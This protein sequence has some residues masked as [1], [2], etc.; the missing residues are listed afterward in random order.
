MTCASAAIAAPLHSS[1]V[2]LRPSL[3]SGWV[4]VTYKDAQVAVPSSFSVVYPNEQYCGVFASTGTIF[5]GA[6]AVSQTCLENQSPGAQVTLV[7]MR[8]QYFSPESLQG[9]KSIRQDGLRL[10]LVTVNGAP[11]YYSPALGMEVAANGPDSLGV[12]STFAPSPRRVVLAAGPAPQVPSSW[13]TISF[14]GLSFPVPFDWTVK[15]TNYAMGIGQICSVPGVAL[16]LA[17]SVVLSTDQKF[18]AVFC[19]LIGQRPQL[20]VDGVQIDSGPYAPTV[21]ASSHCLDLKAL[22]ACLAAGTSY[23][24][25][26]LVLRVTVP[27]R[28]KPV[29]VSIG[30]AGSGMVAR[31]ILYSLRASLAGGHPLQVAGTVAGTLVRLGS[32]AP[33]APVALPGL[34]TARSSAARNSTAT[35]GKRGRFVLSVSPGEYKLTGHSPLVSQE[36]CTAAQLVRVKAGQEIS[37]VE[38]VCST[39]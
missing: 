34:V 21:T 3:A 12:L 5:L 6:V 20:P 15:R 1:S 30:L 29:V 26:I 7:Y 11:G 39:K 25:S 4:E 19:P 10:Y 2:A 14:D 18:Y 36:S 32:P 22:H 27:R 35:V 38:V 9:Y 8:P 33:G 24:Y 17:G 23:V 31:T 37:G 13:R 16:G 28:A